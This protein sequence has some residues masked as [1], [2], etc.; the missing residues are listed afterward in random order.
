MTP[1]QQLKIATN[2]LSF[3]KSNKDEV[4]DYCEDFHFV[5]DI[6]ITKGGTWDAGTEFAPPTWTSE[7]EAEI[8]E[9][10]VLE[11]EDYTYVK[12]SESELDELCKELLTKIEIE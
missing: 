11:A 4:Y 9:L 5:F 12:L 3:S 1:L 6:E 2:K 7:D 8:T 10:S